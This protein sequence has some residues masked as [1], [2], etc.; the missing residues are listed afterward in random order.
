[1]SLTKNSIVSDEDLKVQFRNPIIKEAIFLASPVLFR[2]LKKWETGEILDEK[3]IKKIRISFLKYLSRLSS[4]PTPFGLFAGT[5]LGKIEGIDA[6]II[7]NLKHSRNTRLDMNVTGLVIESIEKN[8]EIKNKLIYFQNTSIYD[9]CNKLRYVECSYKDGNIKHQIVEIENSEYIIKIL[10]SVKNGANVIEIANSI[11]SLDISLMEAVEFVYELIDS[12]IL[13]SEL[14]Q[15]VSGEED[16]NHIIWVLNKI[17]VPNFFINK[18]YEIREKLLIIDYKIGNEIELYR[19]IIDIIKSID[20]SFDEKYLFKADLNLQTKEN[21]LNIDI[22]E[23]LQDCLVILNKISASNKNPN[24]EE[25]KKAFLERY[26]YQ[27]MPLSLVLDE[28]IGLGYPI[29]QAGDD[30]NP[31]IDNLD[32]S[33]GKKEVN[34][35]MSSDFHSLLLKK[36]II[37]V[38]KES[39]LIEILESDLANYPLEWGDLPD[40]FSAITQ[41]VY[42]NGHKKMTLDYLVGSS[43]VIPLA[44]F[45]YN[46]SAINNFANEICAFEKEFNQDKIIAEI[47]HL[48]VRRAGNIL[49]RPSFR[50]Y[51]IPYLSNSL[52]K[53][54]Y[55]IIL[56]DILISIQN[57]EII[58]KSRKDGKEI[59]PKLSTSHDYST[60]TLPVY[61]F[62]CDMQLSNKRFP[63]WFD[64][65]FLYNEFNFFPRLVYKDIV[66]STA[67]WKFSFDEIKKNIDISNPLRVRDSFDVWFKKKKIPQFFYI[68]EGDNKLLINSHNLTSLEM[69]LSQIR[70]KSLNV[71]EELI[72]GDDSICKDEKNESYINEFIFSFYRKSNNT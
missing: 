71:I 13:V 25:F 34:D 64:W 70:N 66:L 52:K 51:E 2:E 11:I 18:I 14:Q 48:P 42:E 27:D 33:I 1:L 28:E 53:S 37:A 21:Y 54:N 59:I 19:E 72:F 10:N 63:L 23:Q 46:D 47:V 5:S 26:E 8:I 15:T 40:T 17:N 35:V 43:A 7:I 45:C 65:G 50:D 9:F 29:R 61:R 67:K 6:K 31:L 36:M 20:I 16:I 30:F 22:V 44:R 49:M 58:L 3:S 38:N 57:D 69:F 32:F 12:Q 60:S 39:F 4:R 41:I 62:L 55:K 24:L 56:D 68:V